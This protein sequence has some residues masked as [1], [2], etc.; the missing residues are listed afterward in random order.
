M[1]TTPEI[2]L[3]LDAINLDPDYWQNHLMD[4]LK[5]LKYKAI[6]L[7]T[8]DSDGENTFVWGGEAGHLHDLR[9]KTNSELSAAIEELKKTN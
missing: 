9:E 8:C 3:F 6:V 5:T 2:K 4:A 1:D 7:S